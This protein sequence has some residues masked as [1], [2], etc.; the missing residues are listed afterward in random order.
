MFEVGKA[1]TLT[2][3]IGSNKKKVTRIK[4]YKVCLN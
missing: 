4:T 3:D 1:N 2:E